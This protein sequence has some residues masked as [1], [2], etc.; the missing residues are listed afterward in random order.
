MGSGLQW[1]PVR[2]LTILETPFGAETAAPIQ[3]FSPTLLNKDSALPY[4]LHSLTL[5]MPSDSWFLNSGL[6]CIV[7]PG[8]QARKGYWAREQLSSALHSVSVQITQLLLQSPPHPWIN[9]HGCL[10]S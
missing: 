1:G 2:V 5:L 4:G 10:V 7:S 6:Q 3:G 8:N 9:S